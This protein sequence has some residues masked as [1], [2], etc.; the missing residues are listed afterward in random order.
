M[1][2]ENAA[3]QVLVT[4][5][6]GYIGSHTCKA[7]A[8]AG[9]TPVSLDN[10]VSGHRRAVRWG[11]FEEADLCDRVRIEDILRTYRI[12]AVIHFAAYA[13]VGESMSAPAKYFRN[14]VV[15]TLTLLEAMQAVGVKKIVFS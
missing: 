8:A 1:P 15:N 3:K 13:Y 6:A 12:D 4:G 7:L 2:D 11:P 14:N 5:G 10:L 9:Y